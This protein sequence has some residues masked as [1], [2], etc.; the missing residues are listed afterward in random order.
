MS[1]AAVVVKLP[2][3]TLGAAQPPINDAEALVSNGEA[4]TPEYSVT[5]TQ[6]PVPPTVVAVMV[7]L[8]AAV[9]ARIKASIAPE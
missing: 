9:F 2:V 4:P 6:V 1:F 3:D 7:M 8:P 5:E